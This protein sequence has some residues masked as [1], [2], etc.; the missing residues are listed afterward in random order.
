MIFDHIHQGNMNRIGLVL[1]FV[2]IAPEVLAMFV[3]HLFMQPEDEQ[4][5]N[6]LRPS[7]S[8]KKVMDSPL[9][10]VYGLLEY[11][12]EFLFDMTDFMEI[13]RCLDFRGLQSIGR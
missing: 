3:F 7:D 12:E 13:R 8:P 11:S 4:T 1:G 6:R 9:S 2:E 10:E 5:E